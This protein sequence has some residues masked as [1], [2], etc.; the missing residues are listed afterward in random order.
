MS[1]EDV[2]RWA[3]EA[4]DKG[5]QLSP[6]CTS[7]EILD[8]HDPVLSRLATQLFRRTNEYLQGEMAV[9]QEHY[10]LLEEINRMVITKYADL[11]SLAMNLSKTLNEYN[12]M[13]TDLIKPLL[14][15]IDQIDAQV[16]QVEVN[17]YLLDNYTKL[18]KARFK[19]LEEK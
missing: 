3:V 4:R 19:E 7:F 11:R 15:Q 8:P 1:E 10:V 5:L 14:M 2:D 6:S 17:A 13:H 9:G 18:L 12:E 16:S